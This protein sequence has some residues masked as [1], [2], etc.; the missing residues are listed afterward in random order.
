MRR[1]EL[2]QVPGSKISI[3]GKHLTHTCLSKWFLLGIA[4]VQLNRCACDISSHNYTYSFEP[5]PHWSHVYADSQEIQQYFEKFK[6]KYGLDRYCKTSHQILSTRWVDE[7][8]EWEVEV[9]DLQ[10]DTILKDFC[11]VLI[12]ANGAYNQWRWPSINGLHDFQGPLLHTAHWDPAV[13]LTGKRV[14]LIGNGY[15][16]SMTFLSLMLIRALEGPRESRYSQLY[17]LQSNSSP[18]SSGNQ[19]G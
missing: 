7:K 6:I 17:N 15:S 9:K 18:T 12:N 13:D 10:N 11:H 5:N 16:F 8:G 14:G 3:L 19:R 2:F 1:T 4:H